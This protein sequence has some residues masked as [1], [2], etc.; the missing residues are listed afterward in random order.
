LGY[1][2]SDVTFAAGT[3]A[4]DALEHSVASKD[5]KNIE[6][7][8]PAVAL[9]E[10]YNQIAA[11]QDENEKQSFDLVGYTKKVVSLFSVEFESTDIEFI[12]AGESKLVINSIPGQIAL[13]LINFINNSI[14]H[15]F[16][17]KGN[18]KISILIEKSAKDGAKITFQ[19][20]GA[21]MDKS[22]QEKV[23]TPFFTTKPERGYLGLGMSTVSDVIKT[24]LSGDIKLQSQQGKGTTLTITL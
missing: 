4:E 23:F 17:N 20:N 9:L 7:L 8:K 14:K 10:N 24:K 2:A 19:D 15:G 13:V 16:D 12:C 18:G 3:S 22:T 5:L 21:G 1:I 6:T 11:D